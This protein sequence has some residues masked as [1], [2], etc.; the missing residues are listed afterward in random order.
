VSK[1]LPRSILRL[2]PLA[3]TSRPS[4]NFILSL[5]DMGTCTLKDSAIDLAKMKTAEEC[6]EAL[7]IELCRIK[8]MGES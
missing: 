8:E 4:P 7:K 2:S 6:I 3:G 1:R 5:Y